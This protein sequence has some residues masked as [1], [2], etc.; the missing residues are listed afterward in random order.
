M[1]KHKPTF[2]DRSCTGVTLSDVQTCL[3]LNDLDEI[4][5]ST[6]YLDFHMLGLFSFR[7]W[8]PRQAVDFWMSFL[9]VVSVV[10]DT[11]T[12]HP[13]RPDDSHLYVDYDVHVTFDEGC[14]WSDGNIGGFCTEFYKDGVEIGNIVMP[15][16][17]CIDCGFGLERIGSFMPGW[18][19][20]EPTRSL[21]LQRCIQRLLGEGIVPGNTKQGY[22]LRK[23]IR[24]CLREQIPLGQH[25]LVTREDDLRR[26]ML[27]ALPRLQKK[28][29]GKPPE[30][31]KDT[32]GID[33]EDLPS[34]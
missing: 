8:L 2:Q 4:G 7:H 31:F 20:A 34:P 24:M 19:E 9:E 30:F 28:H 25:P 12:I 22:V 11:V 13:T 3:R 32:F 18:S 17:D 6:H 21:V 23:L 29:Q 14:V 10:P 15:N 5:D 16:G 1:Q 33:P 26:K 27:S